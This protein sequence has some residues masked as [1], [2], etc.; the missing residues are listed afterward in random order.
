MWTCMQVQKKTRIAWILYDR[1]AGGLSKTVR[2][3]LILVSPSDEPQVSS[4]PQHPYIDLVPSYTLPQQG[5]L[6]RH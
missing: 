4:V 2:K 5:T 3:Y 6:R 1:T